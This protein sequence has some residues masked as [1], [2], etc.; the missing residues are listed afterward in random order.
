MAIKAMPT[1][2][3]NNDDCSFRYVVLVFHPIVLY[4]KFFLQ[5]L[6]TLRSSNTFLVVVCTIWHEK[7]NG[8]T[9]DST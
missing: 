3:C 7:V 4:W 5:V 2:A 1:M 9:V 8:S 6:A